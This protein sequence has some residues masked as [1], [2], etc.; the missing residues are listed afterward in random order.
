MSAGTEVDRELTDLLAAV[1][2]AHRER[3]RTAASTDRDPGAWDEDLWQQLSDLGLARL[4]GDEESGGSGADWF[5]AAAL[6]RAAAAHGVRTPIVEHDLLACWLLTEAGLPVDD[7]RRSACVV[8]PHGTARDVGWAAG[9]ERVVVAWPS[10]DTYR[11]ADVDVSDLDITAGANVAGEPRDAVVARLDSLAGTEVGTTVI[12]RFRLRGAVAR[13]VQTCAALERTLDLTGRHAVEREQFGRPLARFQAVTNLVADIAAETSLA[14]ATT[15]SALTAAVRS[16]WSAPNLKFLVA[17][18]RS[19]TGRA[20]STV[21]RHAHQVHG[22]IG[23]THEHPLHEV[24]L[25]A[26]AWRSEFGSVHEW[27]QIV[28]DAARDAGAD[29]L[30]P[31]IA[32]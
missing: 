3:T 12:E 19:C 5:A 10:G 1:F 28:A 21:V 16:D 22:A 6:L 2:A 18:A 4:T 17:V 7:A 29:G 31:L 24:T 30:W 14:R 27:E 9:A 25:P 20:T 13:A 26:L 15:E 23:T 32:G 11:V 8:D